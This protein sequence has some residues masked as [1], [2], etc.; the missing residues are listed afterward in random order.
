MNKRKLAVQYFACLVLVAIY[1][2][3]VLFYSALPRLHVRHV[4]LLQ[5]PLLFPGAI[6]L[7]LSCFG[8]GGAGLASPGLVVAVSCLEV[9]GNN[10]CDPFYR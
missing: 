3:C 8:S 4:G 10:S 1:L 6:F 2:G 7:G 9:M 5:R